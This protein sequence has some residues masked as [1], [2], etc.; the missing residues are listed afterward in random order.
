MVILKVFLLLLKRESG[1][2]AQ[3]MKKAFS[4]AIGKRTF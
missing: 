2:K 3:G 1:L 4:D